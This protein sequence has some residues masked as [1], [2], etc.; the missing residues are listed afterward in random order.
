MHT[1]NTYKKPSRALA[2][3]LYSLERRMA[4][5][6]LLAVV[7]LSVLY[8]YF[9]GS[10]VVNTVAHKETQSQIVEMNSKISELES[11]YISSKDALSVARAEEYGLVAVNEKS[12]AQRTVFVGRAQ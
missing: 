11:R 5:V 4:A 10:A 7:A 12:F 6:L 1:T 2:Y 8:V 3:A 9:V